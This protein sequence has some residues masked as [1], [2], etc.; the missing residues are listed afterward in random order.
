MGGNILTKVLCAPF[1]Q[2][3]ENANYTYQSKLFKEGWGLDAKTGEI[4]YVWDAGI[5]DPAL[6]QKNAIKNAISIA[7]TVLT[8]KTVITLNRQ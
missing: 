6:I 5:V 1:Y 2:I 3:A 8:A 7:G 4:V